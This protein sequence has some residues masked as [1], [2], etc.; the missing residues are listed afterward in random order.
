MATPIIY[1][2]PYQGG[3]YHH[4]V[5]VLD[6]DGAA[7]DLTGWTGRMEIRDRIGGTLQH[8]S[9]DGNFE[10]QFGNGYVDII[11][12]DETTAAFDFI[13]GIGD[14]FGTDPSDRTYFIT[15]CAFALSQS[16]TEHS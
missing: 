15:R 8:A 12:T 9:T 14:L 1:L 13:K 2:R 7:V 10:L 5:N 11:W 3:T 4:R 6:A 16:A